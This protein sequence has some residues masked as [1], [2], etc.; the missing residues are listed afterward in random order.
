[1]KNKL[2]ILLLAGVLAVAAGGCKAPALAPD[3][4]IILPQAYLHGGADSTHIGGLPWKQFFPDPIL[5][6]YIQTALENNHSFRQSMER[7]AMARTQVRMKKGALFPELTIGAQAGVQKFG[8]YTMD[9]VGNSTTNTPDLAKEKHIPDPYRDFNLGIGFQWEADIWGKLNQKRRGAAARWMASKEAARLAQTTLISEVAAQY[10]ELV[11]LDKQLA[12][13]KRAITDTQASYELTYQLK[14]E[15]EITQLAVDQ[16]KSR[17]LRLEGMLVETEQRI[18]EKERSLATLMGVFPFAVDRITFEEMNCLN[19]PIEA[20]VPSQLLQLR[21]DVRAAELELIA[22]KAD[23]S[24]ARRAFFPSLQ[25]GGS[26]GFNAFD[27]SRWFT[28]P[29]S[30]V[31]SLGAGL[32]APLFKQYE[33]RGLWENARAG[34]RIALEGYHETVLKAYEE[35][36]NLIVSSERIHKRKEL[37]REESEVHHRSIDHANELFKLSFVGYLEVLSADERY[38]DCEL[39]YAALSAQCCITKALLYRALGGGSL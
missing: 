6:G 7:V 31:Y 8:E 10:F 34:Q 25:I 37:K 30:L 15:G 2:Y 3:E 29:A 22:S 39:E 23:L 21:P 11:G 36:T 1:M 35:V 9:G 27:I 14:Q 4:Q 5:Q 17:L 19:F 12:T 18:G 32:T 33:I 13:L 20:G 24:A 28:S 26:A 38:L 16:F